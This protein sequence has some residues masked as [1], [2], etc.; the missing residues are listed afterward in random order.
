MSSPQGWITIQFDALNSIAIYQKSQHNNEKQH[1]E[2]N[3]L[4]IFIE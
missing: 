1:P 3:Y 4:Y 2:I